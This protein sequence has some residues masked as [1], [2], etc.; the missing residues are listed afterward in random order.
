ME[1]RIHQLADVSEEAQIGDGTKIWGWTQVMPGAKIGQ[2]CV[3]GT[4]VT[5]DRDVEIGVNCKIQAGARIYHGAKIGDGVFVGPN[6]V[7]TNDKH[8]R[9]VNE[10]MS[11]KSDDDWEVSGVTIEDGAAI[12][13]SSVLCP[14]VTIGRFATI[15]AGSV[16]T[17]DI[18]AGATAYG[19][20]A[21]VCKQA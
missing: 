8:P 16:V 18:P 6:V 15:G 3:I 7:V 5:I 13:A 19:N 12:G 10:D 11:L 20:P 2:G 9:A 17:R 1:I 14:G 4:H 21:R